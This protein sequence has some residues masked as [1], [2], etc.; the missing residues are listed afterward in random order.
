MRSYVLVTIATLAFATAS[1]AAC[2]D[3]DEPAAGTSSGASGSSSG[4]SGS[5]GT[6]SSSS[7]GTSGSS[8]TIDDAGTSVDSGPTADPECNKLTQQG[9]PV[10]ALTSIGVAPT[11][12]GGSIVDGT[13]VL[14]SAT[15]YTNAVADGTKVLTSA[16]TIE[17][18]GTSVKAVNTTGNDVTRANTTIA[19]S[20]TD[21]TLTPTCNFPE[22]DG[23]LGAPAM[24]EY[25]AT[26]TTFSNF[27]VLN[28]ATYVLEYTKQ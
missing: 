4:A 6:G 13:Y 2:S 21:I 3:S 20:G 5:S 23:G 27:G 18:T 15:L 12:Q 22:K 24:G 16:A 25:T 10:D 1:L 9:Q 14:T 8:G 7:S 19:V 17:I 11:P 26:A 28:G